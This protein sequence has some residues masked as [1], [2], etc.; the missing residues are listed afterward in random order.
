MAEKK[1]GKK[2]VKNKKVCE[3]FEVEKN[4]KVEEVKSCGI[5]EVP[6]VKDGQIKEQNKILRNILIILGVVIVLFLSGFYW[7]NSLR[8]FEYRNIEFNVVHEKNLLLYNTAIAIVQN[9]KHIADYNFYLRNDPRKLE[10]IQF[11]G[12]ELSMTHNLVLNGSEGF[13]CDG[14]EIIGIANMKKLMDVVGIQTIIDNNASCDEAGSYSFIKLEN[15]TE[16]KITKFE[17]SC[18]V[19]EVKDCDILRATERFMVEIF[20]RMSV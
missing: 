13:K 17:P 11:K 20:A 7:I 15:S 4:G 2:K 18:Y 14:D 16:T 8:H 12:G 3:I 1:V 10:E 5:E 6:E 19:I 9:G